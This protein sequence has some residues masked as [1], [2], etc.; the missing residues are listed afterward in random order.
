MIPQ[1]LKAQ[2]QKKGSGT[3]PLLVEERVGINI[4]PEAARKSQKATYHKYFWIVGLI[5]PRMLA[6]M[7]GRR[8]KA[9]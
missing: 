8:K 3:N 7:C 2:L 6:R 5:S 1:Q 4:S 9:L